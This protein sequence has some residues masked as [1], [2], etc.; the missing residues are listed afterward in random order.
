MGRASDTVA[1]ALSRRLAGRHHRARDR[2]RGRTGDHMR[3]PPYGH[4]VAL[5]YA[6][7]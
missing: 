2:Q 7:T 1:D 3:T 6:H 4:D 5:R